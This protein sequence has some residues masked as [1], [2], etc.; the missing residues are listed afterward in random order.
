MDATIV[1]EAIIEGAQKYGYYVQNPI[2]PWTI[3]WTKD[4]DDNARELVIKVEYEPNK[5]TIIAPKQ[6]IRSYEEKHLD[7]AA[8]F[9]R[10]YISLKAAQDRIKKPV[11]T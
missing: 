1:R 6:T 4:V 9:C 2:G 11:L 3:V 10:V 5:V 8:R 7:V